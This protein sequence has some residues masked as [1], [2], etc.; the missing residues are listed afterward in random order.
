[1]F[2]SLSRQ[3]LAAIQRPWSD[4]INKDPFLWERSFVNG[5]SDSEVLTQRG[6]INFKFWKFWDVSIFAQEGITQP[7]TVWIRL[8]IV[9]TSQNSHVLIIFRLEKLRTFIKWC[10][11]R[12]ALQ[13]RKRLLAP[14]R[15]TDALCPFFLLL[16]ARRL[17]L[18]MHRSL[19]LIVQAWILHSAQTQ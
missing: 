15:K 16:R 1:M 14:V 19:R 11:G 10:F 5:Q 7:R 17:M 2:S 3:L 12:E 6:V 13:K 4:W 8:A 18:R 9:A